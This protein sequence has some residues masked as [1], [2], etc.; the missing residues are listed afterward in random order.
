MIL[1]LKN[2]TGNDIVYGAVTVPANGNY[3]CLEKDKSIMAD[4]PVLVNDINLYKIFLSDSVETYAGNSAID[5]LKNFSASNVTTAYEK[6]NVVAKFC[7]IEGTCDANGDLVLQIEVPG[8]LGQTGR[9]AA[10]GYTFTDSWVKG[11]RVK[12]IELV[13]VNNIFGL[14]AGVILES[15]HDESV[16]EAN[17]GWRFYPAPTNSGEVEIDP[18]GYYG[19]IPAGLFLRITYKFNRA[20]VWCA[21]NIFWGVEK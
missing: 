5:Y 9:L 20:N 6:T 21:A 17:M 15:Y 3:T 18:L 10:G 13:D 4:N 8:T 19:Q 1:V 11:D 7:S 2:Q 12:K 14:G 16:T